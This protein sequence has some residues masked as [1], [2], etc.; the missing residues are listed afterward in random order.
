MFF[1]QILANNNLPLKIYCESIVKILW[2]YFSILISY[3]LFYISLILFFIHISFSLFSPLFFL[4]H[5]RTLNFFSL[6]PFFIFFP[7]TFSALTFFSLFPS[8]VFFL[9]TSHSKM[10]HFSTSF[11]FFFFF[12]FF[13]FCFCLFFFDSSKATR[14]KEERR[15]WWWRRWRLLKHKEIPHLSP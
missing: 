15:R 2:Q 7:T 3:S 13:C 12:F 10:F 6:F 4:L 14:I 11:L 9:T 5:T 1:S 8:F